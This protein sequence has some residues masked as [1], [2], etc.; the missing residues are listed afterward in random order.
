MEFG[1][2]FGMGVAEV[3]AEAHHG[4]VGGESGA[5]STEM[6][7]RSSPSGRPRRMRRWRSA[8]FLLRMKRGR[9]KPKAV[10]PTSRKGELNPVKR[11]T[12]MKATAAQRTRRPL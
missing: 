4:L 8:S 2:Q 3:V 11:K 6:T 5:A 10:R 1:A 7:V 12:E 9:K